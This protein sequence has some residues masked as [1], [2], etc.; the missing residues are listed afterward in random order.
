MIRIIAGTH[1]SR[2]LLLPESDTI[3]PTTDKV[4][5]AL[6]SMLIHRLGTFDGVWV[7]DAFCGT[8]AY[9]L[10]AL[11]RGAEKVFFLDQDRTSLSLAKRNAESLKETGKCNFVQTDAA[12]P[13]AAPKPCH[14]LLLDPPYNKGL[15]ETS[16]HALT[17]QGWAEKAA[18][19]AVEVAR[20]EAFTA[21]PG[22][23]ILTER[24]HGPARLI[25]LELR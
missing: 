5:E 12:R 20:D 9:G 25:L 4:R 10:E 7:C 23:T 13:P 8:G 24:A 6:F 2:K 18:L 22:W 16:L 17:A 1:R 21:P 15:A 19:A 3:R 14:L 11:S